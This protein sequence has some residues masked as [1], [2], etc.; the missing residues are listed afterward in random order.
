LDIAQ[1]EFITIIQNPELREHSTLKATEFDT[2]FGEVQ[3]L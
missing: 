1:K 2:K 3:Q